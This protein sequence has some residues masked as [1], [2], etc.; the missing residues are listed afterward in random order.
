M[1]ISKILKFNTIVEIGVYVVIIVVSGVGEKLPKREE[2][3]KARHRVHIKVLV[4][5]PVE[6]LSAR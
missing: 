4:E 1:S 2:A 3:K 5:S 6:W